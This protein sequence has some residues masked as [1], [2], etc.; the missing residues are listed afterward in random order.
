MSMAKK[1]DLAWVNKELQ[2]SLE[3]YEKDP[4]WQVH[5]NVLA[6]LCSSLDNRTLR[7]VLPKVVAIDRLY[8]A[9]LLRYLPKPGPGQP[10]CR[11]NGYSDLARALVKVKLDGRL[12]SLQEE[13]SCLGEDCLEPVIDIHGR[14]AEAVRQVTGLNGEVFAAKYLHF[15]CQDY[16]PILDGKADKTAREVLEL[17]DKKGAVIIA[18]RFDCDNRDRPRYDRF[19]RRILA[20]QSALA[21]AGFGPYTLSQMD[22]YLY[23]SQT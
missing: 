16:F 6:T 7:T 14:V 21:G 10:D 17:V 20:I 5:D 19:C 4:D 13:S 1:T 8:K 23:G 12:A 9:D 18:E 15:C 11:L 22:Q 3:K 2:K